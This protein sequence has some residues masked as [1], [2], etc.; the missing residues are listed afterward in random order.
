MPRCLLRQPCSTT[1]RAA[2]RSLSS[3]QLRVP[4]AKHT[5]SAAM[6]MPSFDSTARTVPACEMASMAYST[7]FVSPTSYTYTSRNTCPGT[8][9][10]Q[11]QLRSKR[12]S[13]PSGEK[14]VVRPSCQQLSG[15]SK[16]QQHTVV[17][18]SLGRLVMDIQ[19]S[20]PSC[21]RCAVVRGLK[22]GRRSMKPRCSGLPV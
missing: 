2:C 6:A 5:F 8:V 20:S 11:C 19:V 9:V 10:L 17:S 21:L 15:S 7:T 13:L 16:L 22:G 14:I 1:G 18:P 3:C 12:L 4:L